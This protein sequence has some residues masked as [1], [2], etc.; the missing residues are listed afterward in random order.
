MS[1]RAQVQGFECDERSQATKLRQF[2]AD[3][4]QESELP[5]ISVIRSEN[6]S[7]QCGSTR[8]QHAAGTASEQTEFD[9]AR[10]LERRA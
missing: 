5:S 3:F 2:R 7:L 10:T 8:R 6:K 1:V 4:R 9:D